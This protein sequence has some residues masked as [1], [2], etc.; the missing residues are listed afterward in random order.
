MNITCNGLSKSIKWI[1]GNY[2]R[3]FLTETEDIE[4]SVQMDET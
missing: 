1:T 4:A 3:I 2:V